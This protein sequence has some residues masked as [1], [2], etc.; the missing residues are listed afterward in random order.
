MSKALHSSELNYTVMEKQAYVLVKSLKNF[1]VYVR[2]SKIMR[3]VP[4]STVKD[5]LAQ[6]YFL[7]ARG[8]WVSKIP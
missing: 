6:Q 8:K 5:I 3:H 2:Y 1:R 7:G 4:H